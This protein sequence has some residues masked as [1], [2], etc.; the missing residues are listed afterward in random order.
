VAEAI[1][2]RKISPAKMITGAI[3]I[4]LFSGLVLLLN[5]QRQGIPTID[6]QRGEQRLQTLASLEADNQKILNHYHWVDKDK[7]IVGV[8]IERAMELVVRD[9]QANH[10][11]AAGPINPTAGPPSPGAPS[12]GASASPGA[13][14]NSHAPQVNVQAAPSPSTKPR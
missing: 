13:S 11:H 8:P 10:P 5:K 7:K 2:T 14:K 12:P 9:L 6:D 4:L 1:P 3:L